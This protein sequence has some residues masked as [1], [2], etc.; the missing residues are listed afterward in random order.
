MAVFSNIQKRSTD[1]LRPSQICICRHVWDGM[2]ISVGVCN[3]SMLCMDTAT[4]ELVHTHPGY[5][6]L[7][8]QYRKDW[9]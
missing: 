5:I 3:F 4:C 2:E 7:S 1:K 6:A 9:I 8:T